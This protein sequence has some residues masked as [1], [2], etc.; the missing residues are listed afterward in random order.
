MDEKRLK[1]VPLFESLGKRERKVLAQRADE[2]DVPEG[3]H[4]AREGTF[5]YEFFVIEAGTAEVIQDGRR[6]RELGAGDFFGEIGLLESE[7]RTA[8]VIATSPMRLIVL[9][10]PNFRAMQREAPDVAE[11]V[12]R[13][14]E[15]R[16]AADRAR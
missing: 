2:V 7:R 1:G 11:Q 5:A 9:T 16:L 10:G 4:L 12:R 14:I 15:E 6:I 13:T 8:S 3:K